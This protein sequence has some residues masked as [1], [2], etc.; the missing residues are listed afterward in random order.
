MGKTATV[1]VA[2]TG[3]APLL[4]QWLKNGAPIAGAT[5]TTYTTPP[6][7]L[8]DNGALLAAR[9]SDIN[10]SVMSNNAVLTVKPLPTAPIIT[11]QPADQT[12]RHGQTAK[13][14]VTVT[15]SIPLIYQWSKNG[16]AIPGATRAAYTT[17]PAT[18]AD[19]N[20][21]FTATISNSFGSTTSR[22]A[23]LTVQ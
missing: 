23:I 5:K 2:A 16:S 7:V 21:Y 9:V 13:F 11:V 12:V 4:Y 1:K 18:A 14:T 20:A 15:G 22:N 10:G 3:V 8:E 19:N 17:P 6:E